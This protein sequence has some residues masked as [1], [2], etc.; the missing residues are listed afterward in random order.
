MS[1]ETLDMSIVGVLQGI[2]KPGF[3]QN[4]VGVFEE[5]ST[6]LPGVIK[7]SIDAGDAKALEES[8]L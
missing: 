3:F 6:R 7:A 5:D 4:L 8:L 1:D 2:K